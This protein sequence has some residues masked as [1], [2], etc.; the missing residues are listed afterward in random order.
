MPH[1]LKKLPQI[2]Y[3][4]FHIVFQTQNSK[5]DPARY[6]PIPVTQ[7]VA[8]IAARLSLSAEE[9]VLFGV[10]YRM[11]KILNLSLFDVV[12][13]RRYKCPG[14]HPAHGIC[15]HFVLETTL[16]LEVLSH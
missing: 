10:V 13:A 16:A 4:L 5:R 7:L 9:F 11:L 14:L 1:L 15:L 12:V 8:A 2:L 3:S 6:L